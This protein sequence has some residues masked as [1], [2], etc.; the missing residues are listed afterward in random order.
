VTR[1]GSTVLTLPEEEEEEEEEEGGEK[2]S[3]FQDLCLLE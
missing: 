2:D 3:N 1:R